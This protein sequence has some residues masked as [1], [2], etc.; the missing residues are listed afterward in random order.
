MDA[1]DV[2][3]QEFSISF[4]KKHF[5]YGIGTSTD[6]QNNLIKFHHL[7]DMAKLYQVRNVE[8]RDDEHKTKKHKKERFYIRYFSEIL[9][10]SLPRCS[11]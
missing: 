1:R 8:T 7:L 9:S 3:K 2:K 4:S 6:F 5:F 10:T 11:F